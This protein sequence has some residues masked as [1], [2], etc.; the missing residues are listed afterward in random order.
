MS[1][2]W[3]MYEVTMDGGDAEHVVAQSDADAIASASRVRSGAKAATAI[4]PAHFAEVNG[5][6]DD[7][8]AAERA[9]LKQAGQWNASAKAA[10]DSRTVEQKNVAKAEHM[11]RVAAEDARLAALEDALDEGEE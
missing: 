9:R 5:V 6:L 11:E 8:Y 4:R 1:E 3:S 2:T 7:A 10:L